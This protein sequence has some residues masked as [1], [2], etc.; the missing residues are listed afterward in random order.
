MV[1]LRKFSNENHTWMNECCIKLSGDKEEK[2]FYQNKCS[3]LCL[4]D[5]SF[6]Q[7]IWKC[8][9]QVNESCVQIRGGCKTL[10][11]PWGRDVLP[12]NGL[13]SAWKFLFL[14][15][16]GV[17]LFSVLNCF[18]VLQSALVFTLK[19]QTWSHWNTSCLATEALT[20]GASLLNF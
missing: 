3:L 5:K 13:Y 8:H 12:L 15:R 7:P 2:P 14:G 4:E 9:F 20:L 19:G 1:S 11:Y 18:Q 10:L 6:L 17:S 16:G